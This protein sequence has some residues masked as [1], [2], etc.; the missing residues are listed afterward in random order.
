M[1]KLSSNFL[2][3]NFSLFS[4]PFSHIA[5]NSIA[6]DAH[7]DGFVEYY[8]LALEIRYIIVV[9]RGLWAECPLP[10]SQCS[11]GQT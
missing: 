2:R 5:M 4:Y 9:S 8:V 10:F 1:L 7:W 3:V 11:S 6:L